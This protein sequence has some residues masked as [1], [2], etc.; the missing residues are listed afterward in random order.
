MLVCSTCL[1]LLKVSSDPVTL[2]PRPD[3]EPNED[4]FTNLIFNSGVGLSGEC[5]DPEP[6]TA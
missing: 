5:W 4:A 6:K 2:N 3:K 1:G